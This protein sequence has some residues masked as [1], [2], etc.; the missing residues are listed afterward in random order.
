MQYFGLE[1]QNDSQAGQVAWALYGLIA[2]AVIM[3]AAFD[4]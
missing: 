2:G 3:V 1:S 4:P